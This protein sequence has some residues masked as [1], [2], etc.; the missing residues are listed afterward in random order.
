[1]K[2]KFYLATEVVSWISW[3]FS[4]ESQTKPFWRRIFL[5]CDLSRYNLEFGHG[6]YGK[7]RDFCLKRPFIVCTRSIDQICTVTYYIKRGRTSWTYQTERQKIMYLYFLDIID[8]NMMY[9]IKFCVDSYKNEKL[10]NNVCMLAIF[11]YF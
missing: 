2:I 9:L 7:I 8:A 11:L 10:Y 1:M 5:I 3:F 4:H 6:R